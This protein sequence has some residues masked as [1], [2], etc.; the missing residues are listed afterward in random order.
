MTHANSNDLPDRQRRG[1][2]TDGNAESEAVAWASRVTT[3]YTSADRVLAELAALAR[4]L[5]DGR[6][7][8]RCDQAWLL[9]QVDSDELALSWTLWAIQEF[10]LASPAELELDHIYPFKLGGRFEIDNLQALCNSCNARKGAT[11]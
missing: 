9:R 8:A 2:V 3:G 1:D 4:R 11:V 7:I 5:Q 10:R 6:W